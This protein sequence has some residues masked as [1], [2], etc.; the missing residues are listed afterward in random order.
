MIHAYYYH[1]PHVEEGALSF[2]ETAHLR[3]MSS[4]SSF[5]AH[6]PILAL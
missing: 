1:P 4:L 5:D 3:I 6:P 2:L